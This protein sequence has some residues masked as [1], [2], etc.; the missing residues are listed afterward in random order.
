MTALYGRKVILQRIAELHQSHQHISVV[1]PRAIGKTLL[2]QAVVDQHQGGAAG[3]ASAAMVDL[4]HDPPGSTEAALRRVAEALQ[5]T[6]RTASGG[7]LAF[8]AK[9]IKIES[10]AEELFEQLK[11]ALEIVAESDRRV[12]LVLDG[13]DPVLQNSAVPRNLWDNLRTLAQVRSLRL[14]TGSRDQLHRLCYNPDARVSDF[15]RIFYDQPLKVGPFVDADWRD[16]F[17]APPVALGGSAQQELVKWT[18]GH[19]DL[20]D[21]LLGRI[22]ELGKG[23][24]A[25]KREVD[26]AAESLMSAGSARLDAL[27]MDCPEETRGDIVQLARG[28]MAVSDIPV[29]RL[30]FIV[31]R[32][33]AGTFGPKVRLINR[34]MERLASAKKGDVSGARQLFEHPEGFAANIRT[35]LELR[36]AQ[37]QGADQKLLQYVRRAVGHLPDDVDGSLGS[38]R[39]I[40]D[41]ALDL[42]WDAEAPGGKVP[43]PWIEQWKFSGVKNEVEIYTKDPRIPPARGR[44]CGLLRLATG[45][46]HSPRITERISKGT[47][48]LIEHM[49]EVGDLGNHVQGTPTLTMAV[50]FCMAAIELAESLSRD[51][52]SS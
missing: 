9:E 44:Q 11:I 24:Q 8:L 51:L 22:S 17:S 3:F 18:G 16:L 46:Q 35:V 14:M 37:V 20:V 48:V 27:W 39:D 30:Q 25:E 45:Q 6:F 32:G 34:F 23:R 7:G 38:A 41:R 15:F 21:L 13:C 28:E 33:I 4:R 1:G 40:L 19:P 47:Y 31:D 50:A 10:N 12:L 5:E 49:K 43:Q 26:A 42:V 2:L 52:T 36:L 29:E